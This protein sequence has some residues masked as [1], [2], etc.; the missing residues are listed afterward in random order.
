M[1]SSMIREHEIVDTIEKLTRQLDYHCKDCP[2]SDHSDFLMRVI[3]DLKMQL[4]D[5]LEQRPIYQD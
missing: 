4:N 2:N 3:N 1:P 5:I